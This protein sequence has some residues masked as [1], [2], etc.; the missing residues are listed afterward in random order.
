MLPLPVSIFGSKGN[1]DQITLSIDLESALGSNTI[2]KL[3][4][5]IAS[6]CR[7]AKVCDLVLANNSLETQRCP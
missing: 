6:F 7:Y 5:R 1:K 2:W 4:S 3:A